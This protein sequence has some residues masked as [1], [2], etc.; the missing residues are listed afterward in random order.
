MRVGLAGSKDTTGLVIDYLLRDGWPLA[1]V[2]TLTPERAAVAQVSGYQDYREWA[3]PE[4]VAV[5]HPKRY[6]LDGAGDRE[7]CLGLG[8]DLLLV[9]GW[10]RLIPDWW[11][12]RLAV[13]AFGMHGSAEPLPSGRGRSPLN[14]SLIQGR[15]QFTTN[16]F[17]Y[18]PGIDDGDVLDD[19]TFAIDG[20][21]TGGSLQLKNTYAMIQLLARHKAAL[22]ANR[23]E[24]RPQGDGEAS[25]Y[26]KRRPEDGEIQ[27]R[28]PATQVDR[29]VRAVT[30]PFPGAFTWQGEQR[31][32]IWE[33]LPLEEDA[34]GCEPGR[35]IARLAD[36]G[37]LVATGRG[38][39]WVRDF[40]GPAPPRAALLEARRSYCWDWRKLPLLD[41]QYCGDY[42]DIP[43]P[44]RY[45]P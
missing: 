33:G 26:P 34:D 6:A 23:L 37:F 30:R 18:Q 21:D 4:G 27:W 41:P 15:E 29:L 17:R 14:W 8:L 16:L 12:E 13:G 3:L 38:F 35:V 20:R 7:R 44:Y 10:Q 22:L 36:G 5:V 25:Y 45:Y 1:A 31:I 43:E 19:K 40:D 2:L 39:Y 28:L 24:L 42:P 11:L 32:N 9:I